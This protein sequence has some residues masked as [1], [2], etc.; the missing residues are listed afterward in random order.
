VK[1]L[2]RNVLSL[3]LADIVRRILGFISVAFLARSLGTDGFGLVNLGFAVL[4]YGTVLSTAGFATLGTKRIAQGEPA[5]IAGQIVGGR[6]V[7]TLIVFAAIVGATMLAVRDSTTVWLIVLFSCTLFPQIFFLDWYFQGKEKMSTVSIGRI[8]SSAVYLIVIVLCI[9]SSNDVL[10]V[11]FG[12]LFGDSAATL[13]LFLSFRKANSTLR[14]Q[15]LPSLSLLKQSLPL[16]IGTILGALTINFP[17][18]ILGAVRTNAEI[19]IYSAAS[20][21]VFFLLVGDRILF[22]LLLPASARKRAESTDAFRIVLQDALYWILLFSLP[23][24]IGGTLLAQKLIVLVFGADYAG[25]GVVFSV[26]IW[27]FFLTMLHTVCAAGLVSAGEDKAYGT[28]MTITS[29][30]YG[31]F[32]TLGAIGY[33]ALGA[34]CGVVIAEGIGLFLMRRSLAKA[35]P[36]RLPAAAFRIFLSAALMAL[37]ML[38]LRS[39]HLWLTIP[40]GAGCYALSIVVFRAFTVSDVRSLLARF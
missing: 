11:A 7:T 34:A 10:W 21:L 22:S 19:G 12:A 35:L 13:W 37:C 32:V 4:A 33:G 2:S 28:N 8:V 5:E 40:A 14:M 1:R 20:K 23:L 18:L 39:E 27:Y 29:I 9:Q 30:A 15:I 16:S 17:P 25:S 24:A 3:F 6:L 36:L 31:I 26:F 38:A